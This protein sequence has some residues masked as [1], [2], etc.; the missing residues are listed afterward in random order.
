LEAIVQLDK[1]EWEAFLEK[2][3][4]LE[5]KYKL[6]LRELDRAHQKLQALDKSRSQQEKNLP[7]PK[8]PAEEQPTTG[9][10]EVKRAS[11]LTGLKA[12]LESV[13][14]PQT[15][16]AGWSLTNPEAPPN[17]AS[18][19]RCRGK[20][21]H[22]TRFCEVCG[23]DFGRVVCSCGRGL[24]GLVRFCDHCGRRV[25]DAILQAVG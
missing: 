10:A 3:S 25:E 6:I 17:Y 12:K 1:K 19:S 15:P 7:S 21:M 4:E 22:A 16:P 18:C 14:V 23:A 13:R 5:E 11:L 8:T 24:S 9:A 20:I 2:L